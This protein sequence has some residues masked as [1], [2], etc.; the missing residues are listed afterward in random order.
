[1][2]LPQ[3]TTD[4]N[5]IQAL[6]DE[7]NDV[8]G[9]SSAQLKAKFDEA[10]GYIKT[11]LN[12]T[13]IPYLESTS[14]AGGLGITTVSG[15]QAATNVQDALAALE[16]NIEGV[17]QGAVADNSINT[18]KLVDSSITTAKL[19]DN[20]VSTAK[21]QA[22]AVTNAKM[23]DSSVGTNELIDGSVATA[24]LADGSVST[25]KLADGAVTAAKVAAGAISN[26]KL[27]NS[28]VV[29]D[30]I[31][32]NAVTTA[33]I[34]NGAVTNEKI[35]EGTL[36]ST[37][38]A[39]GSVLTAKIADSAITTAKIADG[40][41]TTAKIA[42]TNVTTAKIADEAVTTAK[43][44]DGAVTDSKLANAKADLDANSK[45]EAEQASSSINTITA[46]ATLALTDAGKFIMIN[47]SSDVTVTIPLNSSVA[48]P[49]GT[50]I[51]FCRYGSG[52]ATFAGASGVTIVSLDSELT[53]SDQY[54]T[55]ALKK[56]DTDEWLLTGSL[57]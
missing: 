29:A 34:L 54:C 11:Y 36:S 49:A 15:I 20:S 50:E 6:D 38:F 14:G 13:L 8:G 4:L 35:A 21:L 45:V 27:A 24:K 33:K 12:D 18:V 22:D 10:V 9:L 1:M 17:T 48:F 46:N 56:L 37:R 26:S 31:A 40:N 5:I 51:E 41:V 28:S 3:L 43:I 7:P 52:A 16:A 53:I 42:D 57:G 30:N 19:A 39:D 25:A 32:A 55:A 44:D 47:S 23:A 2:S